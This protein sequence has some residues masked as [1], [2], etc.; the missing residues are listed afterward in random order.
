MV[1]GLHVAQSTS[2]LWNVT[3]RG[4][5][6]Q[7]ANKLLVMIDGRSVYNP[8]FSGVFWEL[9]DIPVED[10]ERDAARIGRRSGRTTRPPGTASRF[11]RAGHA[12]ARSSP[13]STRAISARVLATP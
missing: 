13:A 10:I 11:P 6:D 2:S 8:L 7:F 3:A 9:Q 4:F 12:E 5:N 1:P